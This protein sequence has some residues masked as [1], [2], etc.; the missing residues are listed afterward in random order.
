MKAE[1]LDGAEDEERSGNSE[2]IQSVVITGQIIE[3]LAA[4]G[5]PMRLTALAGQ[6]GEPK[7]KMHRHLSTLKHLGFVDQDAKTETYRLGL[8]L[9]YIGQSA[10]DQF[11]LRRL[12]EPY[13][14]RLRDLT[15]QTV[16]LSTPA[17][18]DAIINAVVESP[19]LVT[20]SVRLGY[21]LP[22]HA[23]AQ[24]RLNL[25]FAP[26]AVQQRILARKLQAFTPRTMVDPAK[27][28]ERLTQIRQQLFDVSM[29]ETLLGISAV[30]APILNY[31]NE[32]VGAIAIVG[33]TQDVH[34][35]VDPEQLKLLRACTKAISLRLNSTA[36]EGLGIPNLREFIFD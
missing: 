32:L 20:I 34:E 1:A 17:S 31:D 22:A 16:V 35:P 30:A 15:R 21:R 29:D 13:M 24:G 25:A 8:K 3:A 12:A 23:S 19:N 4:A 2:L 33:T 9:V 10:I 6:L 11:D 26:L 27:L 18:G 28:R 5:Q 14:S 36:Y 7:A